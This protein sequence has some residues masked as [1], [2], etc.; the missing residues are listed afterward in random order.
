MKSYRKK[1]WSNVPTR[2]AFVSITPQAEE[3][4]KVRKGAQPW[5][6]ARAK[7]RNS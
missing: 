5:I 3:Q 6:I 1:L 2:S 7:S 4:I